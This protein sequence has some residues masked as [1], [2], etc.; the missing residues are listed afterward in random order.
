MQKSSFND[1]PS[2]VKVNLLQK[3]NRF[4]FFS[5]TELTGGEIIGEDFSH[6]IW[7]GN[8]IPYVEIY[9]AQWYTYALNIFFKKSKYEKI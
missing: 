9:P 4:I 3:N 2:Y 1:R 5:S 6:Q 8:Q 7:F